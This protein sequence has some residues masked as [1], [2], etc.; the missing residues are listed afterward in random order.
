MTHDRFAVLT[1]DEE[2]H[3]VDRTSTGDDGAIASGDTLGGK[4]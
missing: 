2:E 4:T 3:N 1:T